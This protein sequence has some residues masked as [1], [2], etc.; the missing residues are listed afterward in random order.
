M[1]RFPPI[2]AVLPALLVGACGSSAHSTQTSR[3][4]LPSDPTR[5]TRQALAALSD[6]A[7]DERFT[8]V[9]RLHVTGVA[10]D[11]VDVISLTTDLAAQHQPGLSGRLITAV[12][13]TR[14]FTHFG[15]PS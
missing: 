10:P 5:A 11:M 4:G 8:Q 14:E 13:S 7:F 1:R 2:P 3:S 6:R 15:S 12:T 9:A